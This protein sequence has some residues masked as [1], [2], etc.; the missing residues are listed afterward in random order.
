MTPHSYR[1]DPLSG[2]TVIIAPGRQGLTQVP[3]AT[4]FPPVDGLCPFCEI[5]KGKRPELLCAR[6]SAEGDSVR[7]VANRYPALSFDAAPPL[8]AAAGFEQWPAW[9]AQEVIIES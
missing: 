2:R 1:R 8:D 4:A 9:G 5:C 3:A 6:Y 7:V